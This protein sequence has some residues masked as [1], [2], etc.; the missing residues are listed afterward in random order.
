[1]NKFEDYTTVWV[2][3]QK[4]FHSECLHVGLSLK[5]L[6]VDTKCWQPE[7]SILNVSLLVLAFRNLSR[8]QS[9]SLSKQLKPR[10]RAQTWISTVRAI[11]LSKRP[12]VLTVPFRRGADH[13]VISSPH[14]SRS[15]WHSSHQGSKH[16][17]WP[18]KQKRK[19]RS[20]QRKA[21]LHLHRLPLC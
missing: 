5:T 7:A 20:A 21:V 4:H 13:L 8:L 15:R 11:H 10:T 19:T 18:E 3:F 14:G 16:H 12:C 9:L 6:I 17:C 2:L 1:M